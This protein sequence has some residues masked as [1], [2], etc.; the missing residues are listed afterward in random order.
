MINKVTGK[1]RP[2]NDNVLVTDMNFGEQTSKGGI[3]LRSDDGKSE[4]VK[5]RWG[6]VWAVGPTQ[7]DFKVGDWILVEHGRWTRGVTV[8]EDGGNEIIV[9]RVEVKSIIGSSEAKPEG[10]E[11]GTLSSSVTEATFKPEMFMGAQY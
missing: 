3:V 4:G 6:R 11:L 7:E 1:L 10:L 9:R 2:L 8:V 5:P